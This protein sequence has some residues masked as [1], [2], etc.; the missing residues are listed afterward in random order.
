M[1]AAVAVADAEGLDAVSF[2]RVAAELD[3]RTMTLY[4]HVA[5]K[6]ELL[7]LMFDDLAAEVLVAGPLPAG[8]RPGLA[9]LATRKRDLCHGGDDVQAGEFGCWPGQEGQEVA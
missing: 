8:W 1:A 2:R 7:D 6:V 9:A 5:S 4:S 3:A